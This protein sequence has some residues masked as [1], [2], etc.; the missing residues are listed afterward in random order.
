MTL[1]AAGGEAADPACC[2]SSVSWSSG[3]ESATPPHATWPIA[4]P[5]KPRRQSR[6]SSR[7]PQFRYLQSPSQQPSR[8]R[9]AGANLRFSP[10]GGSRRRRRKRLPTPTSPRLLHRRS[11]ALRLGPLLHHRP[12][13]RQLRRRLHRR[14]LPCSRRRLRRTFLRPPSRFL[15][16]RR[17]HRYLPLRRRRQL[18]LRLL[19]PLR[20][21]L[22]HRSRTLPRIPCP[23]RRRRRYRRA[24]RPR[25]PRPCPAR[26]RRPMASQRLL[27]T[28]RC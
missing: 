5:Q 18:R 19:R 10:A 28:R 2:A 12:S 8:P 16:S 15:S 9:Q 20:R 3:L 27:E 7:P 13:R 24:S 23:S 25:R 22:P 26:W 4:C 17:R 14:W 21:L 11:R 1:A 6:P